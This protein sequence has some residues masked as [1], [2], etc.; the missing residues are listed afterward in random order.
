[1]SYVVNVVVHIKGLRYGYSDEDD[2]N[3]LLQAL[4]Q[5]SP[6]TGFGDEFLTELPEG[7]EFH[8]RGIKAMESDVLVGAFRASR[9]E[10]IATWIRAMPWQP[11]DQKATVTVIGEDGEQRVDASIDWLGKIDHIVTT[12]RGIA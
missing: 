12:E 10:N 5:T 9:G 8:G 11:S 1:M 7:Y 4:T 6:S 2:R 3:P